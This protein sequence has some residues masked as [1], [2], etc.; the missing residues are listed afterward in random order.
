[1]GCC[2]VDSLS[3][4][5]SSLGMFLP[6]TAVCWADLTFPSAPIT[7]INARVLTNHQLKY[8]LTDSALLKA[9][10]AVRESGRTT[11]YEGECP[12]SS[13]LAY[14]QEIKI[15]KECL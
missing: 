6:V 1:M 15:K 3:E 13:V 12:V 9:V 7:V 8:C 14:L 5:V 11:R 2:L 4:L 10:W